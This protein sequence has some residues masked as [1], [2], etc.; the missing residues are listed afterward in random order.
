MT[1]KGGS[2]HVE[3]GDDPS[4]QSPGSE[5]TKALKLLEF[6]RN[7]NDLSTKENLSE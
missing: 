1:T 3:P 7:E 2:C 5:S 4:F 6:E